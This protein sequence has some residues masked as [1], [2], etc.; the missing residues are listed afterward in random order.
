[1]DKKQA[2]KLLEAWRESYMSNTELC[3]GVE[4]IFGSMPEADFFNTIWQC[5]DRHTVALAAALGDTGGWLSWYA[6][7]CD[8]GANPHDGTPP[9]GKKRKVKTLAALLKIIEES[10]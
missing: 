3:S 9:G 6:H 1:M 4:A 2:L 7:D 8:M 10:K 5:F